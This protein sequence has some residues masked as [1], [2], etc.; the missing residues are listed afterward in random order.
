MASVEFNRV[1][2]IPDQIEIPT[3]KTFISRSAFLHPFR[4]TASS[5]KVKHEGRLEDVDSQAIEVPMFS[6]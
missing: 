4:Y 5:T 1:D 3:K 6:K 2:S